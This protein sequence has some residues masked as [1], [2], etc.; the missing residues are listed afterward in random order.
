[1]TSEDGR[2][3][4]VCISLVSPV[5]R[6]FSYGRVRAARFGCALSK[7]EKIVPTR[8]SA[9]CN[10]AR[11]WSALWAVGRHVCRLT[12]CFLPTHGRNILAYHNVSAKNTSGVDGLEQR[13]AAPCHALAG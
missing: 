8:I 3:N 9:H 1:M 2:L 5:V 6:L 13:A 11:I 7:R 4:T 10:T 12:L